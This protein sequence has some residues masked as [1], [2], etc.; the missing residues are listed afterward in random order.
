MNIGNLV[1]VSLC[2]SKKLHYVLPSLFR[3][4]FYYD[5]PS[6]V[7]GKGQSHSV[8]SSNHGLCSGMLNNLSKCLM[9]QCS[10]FAITKFQMFTNSFHFVSMFL[11]CPFSHLLENGKRILLSFSINRV[12]LYFNLK[13]HL[14]CQ[15]NI[16]FCPCRSSFN[17]SC[18][19]LL[20]LNQ[21]VKTLSVWSWESTSFFLWQ[22]MGN[23]VAITIGGSNGH[24]ELNVYK[25]LI[26][27]ALLR[28][29]FVARW[30]TYCNRI[31]S[32]F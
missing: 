19:L 10:Y 16:V 15:S 13:T 22:V 9:I 20:F 12:H 32:I 18:S 3:C 26:A 25:P 30:C 17:C 23:D 11:A 27:S 28:V 2:C 29:W 1:E 5:W 31:Y 14:D 24:F 21:I 7:I 6:F 8:W 4:L